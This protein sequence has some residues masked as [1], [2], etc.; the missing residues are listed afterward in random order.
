MTVWK[1]GGARKVSTRIGDDWIILTHIKGRKWRLQV[2]GDTPLEAELT[3]A[4]PA[5]ARETAIAATMERLK[6]A[7]AIL[8]SRPAPDWNAVITGRWE[9]RL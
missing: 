9:T 1:S 3:A 8:A 7:P 2:W 4:N 5:D 6:I